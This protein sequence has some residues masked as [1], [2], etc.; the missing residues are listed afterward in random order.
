M[1]SLKIDFKESLLNAVY[2]SY[3]DLNQKQ[4]K[5]KEIYILLVTGKLILNLKTAVSILT[6]LIIQIDVFLLRACSHSVSW[7]I[8]QVSWITVKP[9]FKNSLS[10]FE[11]TLSGFKSCL[12]IFTQNIKKMWCWVDDRKL[13]PLDL[14]QEKTWI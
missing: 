4:S 1:L 11:F 7:R 10:C 5:L 14:N 2:V 13:N 9:F 3:F 6:K 12:E 8:F